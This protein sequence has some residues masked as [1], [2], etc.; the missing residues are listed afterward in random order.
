MASKTERQRWATVP[1]RNRSPPRP[2]L[3]PLL[4]LDSPSLP[5]KPQAQLPLRR[6][7]LQ[8]LVFS[9]SHSG[10]GGDPT[11]PS[12]LTE[13]LLSCVLLMLQIPHS[14][15]CQRAVTVTH[16]ILAIVIDDNRGYML[17]LMLDAFRISLVIA[18]KQVL[19]L[20]LLPPHAPPQEKWVNDNLLWDLMG[21]MEEIYSAF[22][23]GIHP[24]QLQVPSSTATNPT[25]SSC[26]TVPF[27]SD[28]PRQLLLSPLVGVSGNTLRDMETQLV[29][30]KV[31]LPPLFSHHASPCPQGKKR[32][33]DLF[34][35]L[36]KSI[37]AT[38]Q[39]SSPGGDSKSKILDLANDGQ[40]PQ[41][42][43]GSGLARGMQ[44]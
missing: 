3:L 42:V 18:V 28:A 22:V 24:Q 41:Q 26:S 2:P 1:M 4:L 14:I 8:R 17:D 5:S 15:L 44:M 38:L 13:P 11:A 36:V 20:P 7:A 37:S 43:M 27:S 6:L 31:P 21:L 16:F 34:K 35:D 32:R 39:S 9:S 23:L 30:A 12:E 19:L 25:A 40:L 33:R 29:D 10:S